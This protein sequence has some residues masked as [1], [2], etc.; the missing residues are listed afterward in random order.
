MTNQFYFIGIESS[1]LATKV[2]LYVAGVRRVTGK[3][4][5]TY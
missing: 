5:C 4:T 1:Q 3:D 2:D